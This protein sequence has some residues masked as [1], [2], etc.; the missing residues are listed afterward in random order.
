[1]GHSFS[2]V[3][4]GWGWVVLLKQ[5]QIEDLHMKNLR[6]REEKLGNSRYRYNDT[7]RKFG[8]TKA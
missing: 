2:G 4:R 7:E 3:S 5:S 8:E 6:F 1:M